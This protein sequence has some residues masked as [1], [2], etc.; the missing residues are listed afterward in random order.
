METLA[1]LVGLLLLSVLMLIPGQSRLVLGIEILLLGTVLA[2]GLLWG[3]LRLPR[4]PDEPKTWTVVP[5]AVILAGTVPMIVAGIS[6]LAEVGG[7]LYWLAV[8]IVLGLVGAV[9]NAWILLVEIQ[10]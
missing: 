8:E 3:R 10:R 4:Q 6:M 9:T 1:L 2:A 5:L 7:G